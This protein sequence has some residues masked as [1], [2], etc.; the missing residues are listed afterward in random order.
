MDD[1]FGDRNSGEHE[2]SEADFEDDDQT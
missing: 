2:G 1:V